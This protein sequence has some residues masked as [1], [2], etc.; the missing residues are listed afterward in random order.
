M[1]VAYWKKF[2]KMWGSQEFV[3]QMYLLPILNI[4]WINY[5]VQKHIRLRERAGRFI[6]ERFL[7]RFRCR[8]KVRGRTCADR[9]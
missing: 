2:K 7:H 6:A 1:Y 4:L 5:Q 8:Y 3:K 9:T